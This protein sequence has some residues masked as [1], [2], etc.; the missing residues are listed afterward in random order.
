MRKI[1]TKCIV[2][3]LILS[4]GINAGLPAAAST[5]STQETAVVEEV[6]TLSVE[7]KAK[8]YFA[9]FPADKHVVSAADFLEKVAAGEAICVL[10]I[11]SAE[12]YDKGH[13]KTAINVPYGADVAEALEQIPDDVPVMVYCYSGQTASQTIALLNLAGKNAYNVSG[14]FT[15]ISKEEAAKEL[16]TKKANT[17]GEETY[18]VDAEV[19]E[20]IAEYYEVAANSGKFNMSAEQVK[21]AL[22]EDEIYLVDIRSENDYLKSRIAGAK[23]N[24]PFGK[25]MQKALA[26]LPKDKKIVFQC[27]SG[28]TA[29]QTLAIARMMGLDAYS[30]S[31]GMGAKEGSGWLGAGYAVV[32]Y[33]TQQFLDAKVDRY[34]ANLPENKNQI[35]AADF[36]KAIAE[37]Q[38]AVILDI[39]SAEDYANGHVQGAINVPYGA[40]VAKTLERIPNDRT[41]YVYCYS[42]QTAS[43]T[44]LLLNLAG[45]KAINVSG[46]FDKGISNVENVEDLLTTEANEFGDEVYAVD[47]DIKAAVA[48]Y[49]KK[50]AAEEKYAKNNVSP[51]ALKELIDNGA[52]DICVVDLRSAED[53]A[54]GHIQGAI[55]LPY[56]KGMQENFDSLPTDKTLILQCYSGQTAS[57]TAAALRIK[58]YKAYNLSGGMGAE[59]GSGWLGAGYTTVK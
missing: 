27:Y 3:A 36:L 24:I 49:Y 14:G 46:G 30:L 47:E 9:N 38:D 34:F 51:A 41:V 55:S 16:T 29:S 54:N 28:Q 8:A 59:G 4:M 33:S 43:Q 17:F 31:G 20:A 7:E 48:D 42:G 5:V 35:S 39:R 37:G 44:I 22:A 23:R 18:T 21:N 40:D 56:G 19:K 26:T 1:S 13:I 57:Q 2:A 25:G 32:K 15:G 58:G 45:K 50:T 10:D 52:K 53:Y 12:D 11:R 6:G